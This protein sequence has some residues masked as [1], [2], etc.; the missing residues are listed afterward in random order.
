MDGHSAFLEALGRMW[1]AGVPV[2]LVSAAGNAR[3]RARLPGYPFEDVR[4]WIDPVPQTSAVES[5]VVVAPP[6]PPGSESDA[7]AV[8]SDV[9]REVLGVK[10]LGL[11]DDFLALGGDSLIAVRIASRLRQRLGCALAPADLFEASTVASLAR[12]VT[13]VNGEEER[14]ETVAVAG[15]REEGW[16]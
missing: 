6:R 15:L 5:P 7:T 10:T 2:D 11:D 13:A 8:V 9:W 12:L 14:V 16:F 3:R 4:L 1:V